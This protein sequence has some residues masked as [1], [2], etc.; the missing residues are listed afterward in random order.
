MASRLP[1]RLS[2]LLLRLHSAM[3]L[4]AWNLRNFLPA[5]PGRAE[6]DLAIRPGVSTPASLHPP[7]R[8]GE[9]P[10]H[11]LFWRQFEAQSD[12]WI[13]R[14]SQH[15]SQHSSPHPPCS[16][17]RPLPA[18]KAPQTFCNHSGLRSNNHTE[19]TA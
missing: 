13:P 8:K 15:P 14:I 18:H 12:V 7:S 6:Q 11:L 16:S 19:P 9:Y 2:P 17:Q 1:L 4:Q 10:E 3:I 5:L